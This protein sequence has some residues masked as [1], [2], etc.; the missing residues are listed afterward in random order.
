MQTGRKALKDDS[1]WLFV[2]LPESFVA[3]DKLLSGTV[4]EFYSLNTSVPVTTTV[5]AQ[6]LPTL[7]SG[8]TFIARSSGSSLLPILFPG[9]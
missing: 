5:S 9:Q 7:M 4:F 3:S 8:A 6:T 1:G 2:D